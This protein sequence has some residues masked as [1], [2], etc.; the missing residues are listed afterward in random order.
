ME[1]KEEGVRRGSR[2]VSGSRRRRRRAELQ[3]DGEG[4]RRRGGCGGERGGRSR[5]EERKGGLFD[6]YVHC[7][8]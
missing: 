4:D 6:E 5:R 7:G 2:L 1:N 3:L 8:Q